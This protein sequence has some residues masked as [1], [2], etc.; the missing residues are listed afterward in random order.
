[1][2]ETTSWQKFGLLGGG[3][4]TDWRMEESIAL[5]GRTILGMHDCRSA[6]MSKMHG[7]RMKNEFYKTF[8]LW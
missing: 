6:A 1:M 2:V 4:C 5:A 7:K 8:F 3:F